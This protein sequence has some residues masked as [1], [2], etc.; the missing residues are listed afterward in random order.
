MFGLSHHPNADQGETGSGLSPNHE[1]SLV[2]LIDL[3]DYGHPL[4][5]LVRNPWGKGSE[6]LGDWSD[7]SAQ[8]TPELQELASYSPT[9]HEDGEFVMP[10]TE[11]QKHFDTWEINFL[12]PDS[13]HRTCTRSAWTGHSAAGSA[14]SGNRLQ[15]MKNPQFVLEVPEGP[16][17]TEC[18]LQVVLT[19]ED[20]RWT[21]PR[22][23]L[24][25]T[26][27]L[28]PINLKMICNHA[29][30]PAF[31]SS[32]LES[33]LEEAVI[34]TTGVYVANRA[35]AFMAF[36]ME[37]G[38]YVLIPSTFD[39]NKECSILISTVASYPVT[40]N[41]IS[42]AA[43]VDCRG[44]HPIEHTSPAAVQARPNGSSGFSRTDL[45]SMSYVKLMDW[46][47][48]QGITRED[49]DQAFGK[50][51]LIKLAEQRGLV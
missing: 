48:E 2:R 12:F 31:G 22:G 39:S 16:A 1:Y 50:G 41:E 5:C 14:D 4:L 10:F 21:Q 20:I 23:V 13:S 45:V 29:S 43:G 51:P 38:T 24:Q 25:Q 30:D 28:F 27:S 3:Q 9:A 37:P 34:E 6:W 11:L 47:T 26:R 15:Y 33:Y 18:N 49:A 17:G 7:Q 32:R 8:W 44:D 19:Q 42:G 36:N 46:A 40:V 35:V